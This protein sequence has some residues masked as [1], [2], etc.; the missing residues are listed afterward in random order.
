MDPR[1]PLIR[2]LLPDRSH[3]PKG[4]PFTPPEA[5]TRRDHARAN[6]LKIPAHTQVTTGNPGTDHTHVITGNPGKQIAHMG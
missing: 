3:V 1:H 5:K 2:D 4:N 6:T